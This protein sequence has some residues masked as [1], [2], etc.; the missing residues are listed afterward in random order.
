ML[1]LLGIDG[2]MRAGGQAHQIDGVGH[3][4]DFVE[5]VHAPDE[6]AFDV[7][8]GAEILHV[9]IAHREQLGSIGAFRADLRIQLR[10][11]IECGAEERED[12]FPHQPVLERQIFR[13]D[14]QL[15]RQP[16]FVG[17][18]RFTKVHWLIVAE[19]T[20]RVSA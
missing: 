9:Q 16:L 8:P 12:R 18:R 1:Q 11:A 3:A 10:P 2:E 14:F 5:V 4:A 15:M 13:H 17:R 20:C 19:S 7:A 6:P